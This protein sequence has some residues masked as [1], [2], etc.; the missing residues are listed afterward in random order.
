VWV[1]ALQVLEGAGCSCLG[2]ERHDVRVEAGEPVR[3]FL[4][5]CGSKLPSRSRCTSMGISPNSLER[6]GRRPVPRVARPAQGGL[7]CRSRGARS[8]RLKGS[9]TPSMV[10]HLPIRAYPMRV[11]RAEAPS[12]D[13]QVGAPPNGT[14]TAK[15][16]AGQFSRRLPLS[17]PA[18]PRRCGV[19]GPGSKLCL[20]IEVGDS[21]SSGARLDLVAP[22]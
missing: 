21:G 22:A 13:D 16:R 19:V 8:S 1:D 2:M 6:I 20:T 10:I 17:S 9:S 7:L 5:T 11:T 18:S 15:I 3:R 12:D 14:A 4:T